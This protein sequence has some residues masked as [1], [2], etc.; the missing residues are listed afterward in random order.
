M[1]GGLTGTGRVLWRAVV[2]SGQRHLGLVAAGV[3]FF[4]ALSM[5]P[6]L[7]AL[8]ALWGLFADPA[9]V[10]S[11]MQGLEQFLPPDAFALLNDQVQGLVAPGSSR[12]GW[13]TAISLG[14]A[15]WSAR[16]G[17]SALVQGINA[18]FGQEARGNLRHQALS[19]LLTLAMVGAALVALATG[20]VVPLAV[21]FLPLGPFEAALIEALRWSLAPLATVLGIGL[22]YRYGPAVEGPR[23]PL[24]SPGLLVAVVLW[25]A[26]SEG[27][28]F[29][30]TNFGSYNKVYG[31]IGAVAALLMW[32]WL[33]AWAILM[34]AAVNAALAERRQ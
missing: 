5:F 20:I 17:M 4:G 19:L 15:L 34:G 12:L 32:A 18:A 11:N 27:I 29:Y 28:R 21:G 23:P 25:L 16:A 30:L 13:A 8:V 31:S 3:A 6:A 26:M 9:I 7:A 2:L 14:I 33:S 24:W 1:A 22:V 10:A